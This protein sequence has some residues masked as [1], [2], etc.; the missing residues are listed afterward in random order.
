MTVPPSADVLRHCGLTDAEV[1]DTGMP[2]LMSSDEEFKK[3]FDNVSLI[4][5]GEHDMGLGQLHFTNQCDPEALH[6]LLATSSGPRR[7]P[8]LTTHRRGRTHEWRVH[9]ARLA[10]LPCAL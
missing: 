8:A 9:A 1:H 2:V 7:T 5:G 4:A 6:A 10:G 3:T